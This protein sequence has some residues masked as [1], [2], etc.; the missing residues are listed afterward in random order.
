[1]ISNI[2]LVSRARKG[3]RAVRE[4][5]QH[6]QQQYCDPGSEEHRQDTIVQNGRTFRVKLTYRFAAGELIGNCPCDVNPMTTSRRLA[7]QDQQLSGAR[8]LW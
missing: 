8:V 2:T 1:M 3:H 6:R 7:V 4:S 5:L